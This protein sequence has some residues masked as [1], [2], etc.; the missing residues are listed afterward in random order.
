MYCWYIS[1]K[2][3]AKVNPVAHRKAVRRHQKTALKLEKQGLANERGKNAY[4]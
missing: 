2:V 3:V 4:A 1:P